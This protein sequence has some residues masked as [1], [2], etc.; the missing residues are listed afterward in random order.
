MKN[1][2][3][4]GS[5]FL[6]L[7]AVVS[8]SKN[9]DVPAVTEPAV[10]G[11]APAPTTA[12]SG[13]EA[14]TVLVGGTDIG[15][16]EVAHTAGSTNVEYEYRNNGRGP[17]ISESVTFGE[18]GLPKSWT[19]TGNTTFGNAV[20]EQ[21]TLAGGEA[22]WRDSTG[23]G[24]ASPAES[25]LYV[26]Q[27]ASPYALW[28]YARALL[29]DDDQEMQ[30]LPGG[31]LRLEKIEDLSVQG[32][33]GKMAVSTYALSGIDLNPTYFLLDDAGAFFA[34]MSPRFAIVREGF[35]AEDERIRGLAEE[36]AARRFETIQD[37]VARTFDGPFRV[38]NVRVFD[39]A[40]R[41][42]SE[43]VSVQVQGKRISAVLPVDA[44]LAPGE[45]VIDGQGGTL[46]AGM[47][48]MHGH[49]GQ[50]SALLNIAAGVTSVRDMGNNNDVLEGLIEK[51]ESGRL[52]GPRITRSGFIEGKSPH[53]SNN[54]ELVSSQEEALAAVQRYSTGEFYQVKIYNSM[55]PEWVPAMVE[56][57]HAAGM[58]VA[59]HVPAFSNADAMIAAGY[60]E[61]T[62]INQVALGW[63]LEEGED[64]RTLLRLTALRRLPGLDLES[65]RVMKTID[66]MARRGV[67]MDPTL[68]IHETLLRSRN[69]TLSPGVVDYID[70]MPVG[71]QRG[72]RKAWAE[73]ASP[74]DDQAYWQ[75]YDKLVE[76]LALMHDRGILLVPGTDLGGSFAYHRELEL[77]QDVGMT[78]PEI[79]AWA[80]YGMADYLGQSGELGS[81]EAGK[82]ADFFL[83]PGDPTRDLRD[84][85]TIALVVADGNLYFPSEIYPEFGIEPFIEAPTV[86]GGP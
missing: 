28:I 41:T 13:N 10:T 68:A 19:I 72:A 64:T 17:T 61:M 26:A 49:L 46:L 42:R 81:I 11:D 21:F 59:G 27:E 79:L 43:P 51:I 39:P 34:V 85:K 57:A 66:A 54:G 29:A 45:A 6:L 71:V 62:H 16:L 18:G 83:V 36:Y 70:N 77:Y 8:C 60:D 50:N 12:L 82:L 33:S 5:V 4:L 20:D 80:S 73:I 56:A 1:R 14:F 44:P 78:P 47:Y 53:S 9:E 35:E 67:A 7:T 24:T 38:A 65:P 32:P 23:S 2:I 22:S 37:K 25:E 76:I 55:N 52:A 75:A 84:I 48:E 63:V 74:E 3:L 31:T 58:K 69:G 30:V 86:M 40:T 15:Q